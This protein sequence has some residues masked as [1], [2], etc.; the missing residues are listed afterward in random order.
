[1]IEAMISLAIISL[2]LLV[3][4]RTQVASING[5]RTASNIMQAALETNALTEQMISLPYFTAAALA[6]AGADITSTLPSTLSS[7][8]SGF[9][10][11]Y[12]ITNLQV[13]NDA[14]DICRDVTTRIQ[15]FEGDS[16]NPQNVRFITTNLLML[17][18]S[19]R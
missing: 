4:T 5:N 12:R 2:G 18:N 11:T 16:T 7:T 17:P 3:I 19:R 15:W 6:T 14:N 13:G 10:T 9:T 8:S 1:M